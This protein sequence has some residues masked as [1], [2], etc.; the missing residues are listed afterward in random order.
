MGKAGKVW[1]DVS[2]RNMVI[3]MAAAS[4]MGVE[5]GRL[6]GLIPA[7]CIK[8]IEKATYFKWEELRERHGKDQERFKTLKTLKG[9]VGHL[10]QLEKA[11][12]T[13]MVSLADFNIILDTFTTMLGHPWRLREAGQ[14]A[15]AK[16]FGFEAVEKL[17]LRVLLRW[18]TDPFVAISQIAFGN[19]SFNHNKIVETYRAGLGR[20]YLFYRFREGPDNIPA[21]T[22]LEDRR[23]LLYWIR[24]ILEKVA[25]VWPTLKDNWWGRF[26][27]LFYPMQKSVGV[28]C[29]RVVGM[30]VRDL[31]RAEA[32]LVEERLE[33]GV[34]FLRFPGK[35]WEQYGQ[36][37][38]L[39]RE[40]EGEFAGRYLGAWKTPEATDE[41]PLHGIRLT[42]D[43]KVAAANGEE[44]PLALEDE[45]YSRH[46]QETVIEMRWVTHPLL[47]HLFKWLSAGPIAMQ[48]FRL[49]MESEMRT[50]FAAAQ[51]Q[52]T[53]YQASELM[54][55]VAQAYPNRE[56]TEALHNG[57]YPQG[58]ITTTCAVVIADMVGFTRAQEEAEAAGEKA[59]FDS[60]VADTLSNCRADAELGGAWVKPTS[61]DQIIAIFPLSWAGLG[62]TAAEENNYGLPD[63]CSAALATAKTFRAHFNDNGFSVR[64]ASHVGDL[65]FGMVAGTFDANGHVLSTTAHIEGVALKEMMGKAGDRTLLAASDALV[66]QVRVSKDS[67]LAANLDGPHEVVLKRGGKIKIHLV[68]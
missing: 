49:S 61:G 34:L 60:R 28:V 53:T 39:V 23:S 11:L 41:N 35:G 46:A 58:G 48:G 20:A 56:I 5:V 57:T 4:E 21:R 36:I 10:T 1:L 26:V 2:L 63:V 7:E 59:E 16:S 52:S 29:Y 62:Q 27:R 45:I 43:I 13:A 8:E 50:T 9:I 33:D 42:R 55:E 22:A 18:F 12:C 47:S 44:L 30:S 32:S 68:P 64:I 24:G 51:A 31:L 38:T 66:G 19:G 14:Y 67:F 6:L 15:I 40:D 3:I 54:A 17:L 37:V 25:S 65:T